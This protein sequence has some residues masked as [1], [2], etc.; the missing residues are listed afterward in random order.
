M[1]FKRVFLYFLKR[2]TIGNE[3]RKAIK[4]IDRLYKDLYKR[5]LETKIK[6]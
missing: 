2:V 6:R 5:D 3:Y 4:F 1:R